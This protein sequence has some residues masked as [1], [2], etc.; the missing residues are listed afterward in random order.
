[1]SCE[2]H[3][4]LVFLLHNICNSSRCCHAAFHHRNRCSSLENICMFI[5]RTILAFIDFAVNIN[6]IHLCRNDIQLTADKFLTNAGKLTAADLAFSFFHIA[7]LLDMLKILCYLRFGA[8]LPSFMC[9][10]E[11]FFFGLRSRWVSYCF[12]LIEKCQLCII[13]KLTLLA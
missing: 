3:T 12:S 13:K 9:C 11:G 5:I 2:R 10:N 7:D 1:M 8:F 4:K 6:N